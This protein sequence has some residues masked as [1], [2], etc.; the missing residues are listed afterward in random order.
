MSRK[1]STGKNV[2]LAGRAVVATSR[3]AVQAGRFTVIHWRG[4]LPVLCTA[5]ALVFAGAAEAFAWVYG[6]WAWA[7]TAALG[8][9]LWLWADSWVDRLHRSEQPPA[10]ALLIFTAAAVVLLI[11]AGQAAEAYMLIGLTALAVGIWWWNGKAYQRYKGAERAQRRMERLLVKLGVSESTRVT[12]VKTN[13]KGD[14]EWRLYLGD[15][16]RPDQVKAEDV[17]HLLKTDVSRVIVRRV[18]KGSTRSLKVVH[19]AA[20]PEKSADPVH[21]AVRA[22]NRTAGGAWEPGTRSVLEGL[23]SGNRLGDAE[24]S[25]IRVY[26]TKGQDVRHF[27]ILGATGSGKTSTTSGALLSA[28]ACGDLIL[29]VCDIPKAGNTAEPFRPALHRVATSYDQLEADLR[30]LLA[31]GQDR[32]RRMSEGKVTGPNGR[33]LRKW[34]PSRKTPAVGYLIEELGNTMRDLMAEDPDRAEV[35]WSL[36]ISIAQSVRQAGIIIMWVSQDAKRESINTTFRKAMGSYVVHRVATAQCVNGIWSDQG[37]DMF[38]SGLPSAGM[39]YT[40]DADGG[41]PAKSIGFDMD[42]VIEAGDEFD[43]AVTDFAAARPNASA[44]DVAVLGWGN[45]LCTAQSTEADTEAVTEGA[46]AAR[47]SLAVL[48]GGRDTIGLLSDAVDGDDSIPPGVGIIGGAAEAEEGDDERLNT[49]LTA[50]ADAEDGL[51]RVDVERLLQVS[52]S[53]S[54]RLLDVLQVG[55]RVVREGNGK[56]IRYRLGDEGNSLPAA[57]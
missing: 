33:K 10:M 45:V 5:A 26:T 48:D 40:G 17:A 7:W 44:D 23:P 29:G 6:P 57:A 14:T 22:E 11:L 34:R 15:A 18:E 25:V 16:D 9:L 51:K 39:N 41:E 47:P 28:I 32:I 43:A 8:A 38:E 13:G 30:G 24:H 54:K 55:G 2:R 56:A 52:A 36:L 21:P 3:G 50:L 20:S 53:T 35:L 42:T 31:L 49:I 19:L 12:S 37:L 46:E 27:G 4:L 1:Q